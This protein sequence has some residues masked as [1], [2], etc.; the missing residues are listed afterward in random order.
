LKVL[1]ILPEFY[2]NPGGG[3][4]TFY[5]HLLPLLVQ[6][7]HS[8]K[9]L[10]GSEF[11]QGEENLRY[12]GIDIELLKPAKFASYL[13][14]LRKLDLVPEIQRRLAAAWAMYDQAA[15]GRAY[16]LIESTDWG[17]GY[18]PWVLEKR[19]PV[20]VRLH[21]S[22]A[23]IATYDPP[24][25]LRFQD[26]LLR[27]LEAGTLPLADQCITYSRNNQDFWK[28]ALGL[29][30]SYIPPAYNFSS[31]DMPA[32]DTV[33][34]TPYILVVGRIQQW[35]GPEILCQALEKASCPYPVY[36]I[37]R[38]TDFRT[39]GQS[40]N[41]YL[42]KKYPGLWGRKII[43]AG[44]KSCSMIRAWM[45][46]A[47]FGIVPS[48]WD[49]FNFTAIEWLS[50]GKPVICSKGAG[51]WELVDQARG[52][53]V[54]EPSDTDQLAE[55]ISRWSALSDA[56]LQSVGSAGQCSIQS[57]LNPGQIIEQNLAIYQTLT[58]RHKPAAAPTLNWLHG[59]WMPADAPGSRP[60]AMKQWPI[61]EITWHVWT[62]VL[63]KLRGKL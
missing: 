47:R 20:I 21:G 5:L 34:K 51:A 43:P 8:I 10:V 46:H 37:G 13:F 33:P 59:C 42:M 19:K 39:K 1:V 15:A 26:D 6:S 62:R 31:K 30:A 11:T 57:I 48:T 58:D 32:E 44:Q 4:A 12:A 56:A 22:C 63:E 14:Q 36:W 61:R 16:D 54:F 23:Q 50:T 52:G 18:V 49:V 38:D 60:A 55:I 17:L 2:P 24:K 41:Q 45:Q 9:V 40:C 29:E 25:G 3:I 35:K 28:S 27:A 53:A 7:G